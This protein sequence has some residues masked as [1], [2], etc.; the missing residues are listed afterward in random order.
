MVWS[1]EPLFPF[2][3]YNFRLFFR[4]PVPL[5]Y[6]V[7][8][9]F[10]EHHSFDV[11]YHK[12]LLFFIWLLYDEFQYR[13]ESDFSMH[14]S[15]T[16]KHPVFSVSRWQ[17]HGVSQA[18]HSI[19]SHTLRWQWRLLLS[20]SQDTDCFFYTSRASFVS[21]SSRCNRVIWWGEELTI[22]KIGQNNSPI[23]HKS[24]WCLCLLSVK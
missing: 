9:W 12:Y 13:K 3:T 20:F 4:I 21:H 16:V 8:R 10:W 6:T 24:N 18:G 2:S 15:Q 14:D 1:T 23:F 5:L 19:P 17:K 7:P 11:K 22:W